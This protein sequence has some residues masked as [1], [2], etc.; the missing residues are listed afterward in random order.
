MQSI[1]EGRLYRE[2]HGTFE[3]YC[4]ER[5]RMSKPRAYQLMQAAAV[6]TNVDVP[7]EGIARALAPLRDEP[8]QM[9]EAWQE[10][11]AE[12]PT[13]NL[14]TF[15]EGLRRPSRRNQR[16]GS[17]QRCIYRGSPK[18]KLAPRE[19]LDILNANV[20]R[21]VDCGLHRYAGEPQTL[22]ETTGK[23]ERTDDG[24]YCVGQYPVRLP[25]NAT[26]VT[27]GS[28]S[29]DFHVGD[30]MILRFAFADQIH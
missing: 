16:A 29:L 6:S 23:L 30:H 25:G 11:Q 4:R 27:H 12:A 18:M 2:T 15:A 22:A 20:G 1:R 13:V 17:R 5:W 7:N 9:R 28:R 3:D 26:I 24:R 21:S 10:A 8:G 19:A 14:R